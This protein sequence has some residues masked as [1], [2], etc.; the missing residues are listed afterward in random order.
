[1]SGV[2]NPEGCSIQFVSA[3]DFPDMGDRHIPDDALPIIDC[4]D[5]ALALP[6]PSIP[7][8]IIDP[9]GLFDG[10]NFVY[11]TWTP[12]TS[13]L[14]VDVDALFGALNLDGLSYDDGT[15]T[16]HAHSGGDS[17]TQVL[18]T[19][20]I[21]PA[22]WN[23]EERKYLP[24]TCTFPKWKPHDDDDGTYTYDE[25]DTITF[26]KLVANWSISVRTM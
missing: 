10:I 13:T 7:P 21:A 24:E 3:I 15:N 19:S 14:A 25:D 9:S 11:I 16:L 8:D 23:Q 12:R 6:P 26:K 18:I 22:Q 2:F 17:G 4:A 1:M 20:D 5:G